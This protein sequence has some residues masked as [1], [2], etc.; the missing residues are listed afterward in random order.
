MPR[1]TYHGPARRF[2]THVR[3]GVT[4]GQGETKEVS[5]DI[6]PQLDNNDDFE[7]AGETCTVEKSDGE[8]CGRELPCRFHSDTD[9]D[10]KA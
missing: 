5:D 7:R 10:S 2:S 4:F 8:V 9:D 1:F 6:A 3:G